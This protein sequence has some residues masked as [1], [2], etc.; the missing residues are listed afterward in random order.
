MLVAQLCLTLCNPMDCS[1]PDS[2]VHRTFQTRI[3]EWVA[4]SFSKGFSWPRDQTWVSCIAGWLFTLW[5]TEEA[6]LSQVAAVYWVHTLLKPPNKCSNLCPINNPK[7]GQ[8]SVWSL[9]Y[10]W[11]KGE[12]RSFHDMLKV[13]HLLGPEGSLGCQIKWY[14]CIPSLGLKTA[15]AFERICC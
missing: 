2:S 6:H 4:T 3:L 9:L 5:A 13:M 11:E 12:W 8:G 15:G 7:R 10:R 14:H 1:L